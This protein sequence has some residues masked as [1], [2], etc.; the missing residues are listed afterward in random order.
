MSLR[1]TVLA[2]T[3]ASVLTAGGLF[4]ASAPAS[5]GG[6]RFGVCGTIYNGTN[7]HIAVCLD[8]HGD[9]QGDNHYQQTSRSNYCKHVAYVKPHTD[10]GWRQQV[11]IDAF[12][13]AKG[14]SYQ[15]AYTCVRHDPKYHVTWTHQ[16]SGW[17]KFSNNC[18]EDI[19]SKR[20]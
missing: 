19:S 15:G 17:W 1:R 9:G 13:I 4:A 12:F 7:T 3:T 8:W 16:R 10:W 6:C 20:G 5:A 2:V 11:D 14:T 18:E